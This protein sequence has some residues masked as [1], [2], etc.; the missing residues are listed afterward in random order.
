M[1]F[2]PRRLDAVS[3]RRLAGAALLLLVLLSPEP[4]AALQDACFTTLPRDPG[5]G[6]SGDGIRRL[7]ADREDLL[8]TV[9]WSDDPAGG[10]ATWILATPSGTVAGSWEAPRQV[11]E[12]TEQRL[13][14][15]L[16]RVAVLGFQYVLRLED[17]ETALAETRFRAIAD[18]PDRDL[19]RY[20]LLRGLTGGPITV[21]ERLWDAL[22][23]A[24]ED[25]SP[26]LIGTVRELHSELAAEIPGLLWQM[27][28]SEPM[29]GSGCSCRWL[30]VQSLMPQSATS[31]DAGDGISQEV[32]GDNSQGAGMLV[33]AQTI[34]DPIEITGD[35]TW[36]RSL[37]GIQLLCTRFSGQVAGTRYPTSWPSLPELVL[38][39]RRLESCPAPCMPTIEHEAQVQGCVE[40]RAAGRH[41]RWANAHSKL[42]AWIELGSISRVDGV[43]VAGVDVTDG[44]TLRDAELF[45]EGSSASLEATGA[46]AVAEAAASILIDA[47][48]Q[49]QMLRSYAWGAASV[50]YKLWFGVLES[51]EG[52]IPRHS[53]EIDR[54]EDSLH[55]GGVAIDR[56]E[57]P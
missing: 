12:I 33:A 53:S 6:L 30:D 27:Q 3:L 1:V 25:D 2:V 38:E 39:Q 54:L 35:E 40:A 11:G 50:R 7:E 36:G 51:C 21:S 10:D 8:V 14:G 26:D 24:R 43:A 37:L 48:S 20:R 49:T 42:D 55:E 44:E 46:T 18:C 56:W 9:S 47:D 32:F 31:L 45:G 15:A 13:A 5:T 16:A 17:G 19:C 4:A 22:A 23:E 29:P 34:Q 57:D 52:A 41:G 28:E